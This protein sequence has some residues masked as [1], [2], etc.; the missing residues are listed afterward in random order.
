MSESLKQVHLPAA[1]LVAKMGCEDGGSGTTW[2]FACSTSQEGLWHS[3]A[4]SFAAQTFLPGS[5]IES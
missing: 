5:H 3:P 4:N 2:F 1:T